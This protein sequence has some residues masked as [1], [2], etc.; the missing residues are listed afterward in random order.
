M[1]DKIKLSLAIIILIIIG[2]IVMAALI[3]SPVKI[4]NRILIIKSGDNATSIAGRL[5]ELGLI[6]SPFLF[7]ELVKLSRADRYLKK[8][9]YVFGGKVSLWDTIRILREGKS[10]MIDI[11]IPEGLS[12]Y[13]TLKRIDS[14][15]LADFDEL[16]AA[17]TDAAFI[18]QLTGYQ[19]SSLEGFLYPETYRFDIGLGA[20][21]IL[22]MQV[23]LFW[24]RLQSAGITI[25]DS[26]AFYQNMIL[27]SIVEKEAVYSDEKPVIAGV[28]INR[29]K[30]GMKLESC[31]T[32]DYILEKKGIRRAVLTYADTEISSPYN[33]YL[34]IALPPTPICTPTV[35]SLL[36]VQNAERHRYLYFFADKKGRNIFSSTYEEHLQKQRQYR[37]K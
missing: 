32:V 5:H 9:T 10:A 8:G 16:Y 33:T 29:I 36:A 34:N 37:R 15:G 28:F 11:T 30:L 14:S 2:M 12:L 22:A 20:R 4:D 1:S 18:Q 27:A 17:A 35:S 13:R 3:L 6:R 26:T 21:D 25:Q 31:P 24:G 23:Q 19:V 7:V